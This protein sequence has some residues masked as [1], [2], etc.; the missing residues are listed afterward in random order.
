MHSRTFPEPAAFAHALHL[1]PFSFFTEIPALVGQLPRHKN[2]ATE[3]T[4]AST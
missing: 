1:K 4:A 2:D 3:T